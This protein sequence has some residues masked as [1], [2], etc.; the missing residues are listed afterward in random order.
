VQLLIEAIESCLDNTHEKFN[1]WEKI[2]TYFTK[3]QSMKYFIRIKD[4][5]ILGRIAKN[6]I[7]KHLAFIYE[8]CSVF[9]ICLKEVIE[10]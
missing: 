4:F 3:L 5:V 7:T 9:L 6:Y 2:F 8:V 1:I 10:I